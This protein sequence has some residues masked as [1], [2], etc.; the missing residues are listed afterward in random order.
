MSGWTAMRGP[1]QTE[2]L[3]LVLWLLLSLGLGLEAAPTRSPAQTLG[4]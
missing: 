4:E 1:Q 3:G 2:V